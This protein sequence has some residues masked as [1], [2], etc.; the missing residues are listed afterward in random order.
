MPYKN[1]EDR[2][3]Q[4][5]R[6]AEENRERSREIKRRHQIRNKEAIFAKQKVGRLRNPEREKANSKLR[7]AIR[8]GYIRRPEVGLQFHHP[9]YSRPYFGVWVTALEHRRIHAGIIECPP[10]IDYQEQV[11]RLSAEARHARNSRAA[12]AANKKRWG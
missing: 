11:E 12:I 8:Q 6:W 3:K 2:L 4:S 1:K 5:R 10:C 7:G 9:D